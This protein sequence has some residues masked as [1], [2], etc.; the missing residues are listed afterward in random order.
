M[1]NKSIDTTRIPL[2]P[3]CCYSHGKA[4]GVK[5]NIYFGD[6]SINVD[7]VAKIFNDEKPP[8][9]S[10]ISYEEKKASSVNFL[11]QDLNDSIRKNVFFYIK[12][13]K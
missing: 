4:R 2:F 5:A 9:S 11:D 13:E 8:G 3:L 6:R 10:S 7:V 12:I 1:G